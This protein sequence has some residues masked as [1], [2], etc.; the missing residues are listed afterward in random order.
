MDN[1][2]AFAVQF[3]NNGN[4]PERS[5]ACSGYFS[6]FAKLQTRRQSSLE[7]SAEFTPERYQHP[8]LT[9]VQQTLLDQAF[10]AIQDRFPNTAA[11]GSMSYLSIDDQLERWGGVTGS[12]HEAMWRDLKL[13]FDNREFPSKDAARET[14][15]ELANDI[16][17]GSFGTQDPA[18]QAGDAAQYLYRNLT[19]WLSADRPQFLS[20]G[21]EQFRLLNDAMEFAA[22]RQEQGGEQL[23]A[24]PSL[25]GVLESAGLGPAAQGVLLLTQENFQTAI[26]AL[27]A[28]SLENAPELKFIATLG[29]YMPEFRNGHEPGLSPV[30][31]EGYAKVLESLAAGDPAAFDQAVQFQQNLNKILTNWIQEGKG[32][33]PQE[34]INKAAKAD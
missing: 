7:T 20:G 22:A 14:A 32:F 2:T 8:G 23:L 6:S 3:L 21:R 26:A 27:S 33:Y 12:R 10:L 4:S 13:V 17:Q 18:A 15:A 24:F 1:Q 5:E 9:E 16:L 11:H 34:I 28:D 19:D 25:N 30:I 31:A 29:G